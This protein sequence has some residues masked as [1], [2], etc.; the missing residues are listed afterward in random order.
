MAYRDN[1]K[2]IHIGD[3]VIGGGNP[4]LIQSMTNTKTEDVKA[5]VAQILRLQEAGCEI[6]RSTVPTLEAAKAISEIKKQI[7]IPIVADI[8]FDYKMAIAAMENGADKIRINPGNIGSR[9]RIAAVVSC[10]KERNIPIRVGVNSGSL[11]KNL[12]EKYGG[13]TAEGLVESALDKIGII[14]DL[15]YDN[16]VVSIKSS[17]VMLCVKAHELLAEKCSYPL[18]VGIT[19]AGT[20]YGGNIK[21]SVGLGIILNEGI[22][23]TI[24]V[25]LSGD[26]VEE[27]KT[28]KTILKTLGMRKG[29]IEV[30]SC[31]T[32]G[33][34]N[35]DLIGL[36]NAVENMVQGYD[37]DIK[38]A[39]MGCAVNGPG[40]A[41]EADIG[42]AGGL[43]EG[44][45]IKKGEVVKKVPEDQLLQTLKDELD[46]FVK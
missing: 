14:E 39:V 2:V 37:L 11:E 41:R 1:T 27:I 15:G 34:T 25:S 45:L 8:H 4:V 19:E 24:R 3:R 40:E 46:S 23:D 20:V 13:V 30:V 44:L 32:C 26:P 31:P 35:I 10:A 38:V 18:H 17:N 12:V 33:R 42:I 9:D 29:G 6:I 28:A 43:H 22:G 5:T 16:M 21:S 36:A 7:S